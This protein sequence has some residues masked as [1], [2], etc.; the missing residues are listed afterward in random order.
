MWRNDANDDSSQGVQGV[1]V[2]TWEPRC[3]RCGEQENGLG[4]RHRGRERFHKSASGLSLT[5]GGAPQTPE[6]ANFPVVV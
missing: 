5:L 1:Q 2:R 6:V 4:G 3:R